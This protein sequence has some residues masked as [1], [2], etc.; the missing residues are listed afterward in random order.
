VWARYPIGQ[1]IEPV[2][3]AEL[4]DPSFFLHQVVLEQGKISLR[5]VS[6]CKSLEKKSAQKDPGERTGITKRPNLRRKLGEV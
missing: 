5:E 2:E 6:R 1:R 4:W 3:F